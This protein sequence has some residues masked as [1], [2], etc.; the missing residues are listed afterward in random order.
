MIRRLLLVGLLAGALA[1]C[2][3]SAPVRAGR[4]SPAP[5]PAPTTVNCHWS[6]LDLD[7]VQ[8][9]HLVDAG[10]PPLDVPRNRTA[11]M[12]IDTDLGV[13]EIDMDARRTP[14]AVAS[15]AHLAGRGFFDGTA[16]HRLTR[17]GLSVLQCGDPSGNGTGGPTY[18]YAEED[19]AS[20]YPGGSPP[21]SP[22]GPPSVPTLFCVPDDSANA[23]NDVVCGPG[24]RLSPAP[25]EPREDTTVI[26]R[27][28]TVGV[29]RTSEPGTSGSQFFVSYADNRLDADY[30]PLGTV[31]RGLDVIDTVARGGLT[32]SSSDSP[33]EGTPNT[34]LVLRRVTVVYR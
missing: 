5:T 2:D 10:Y 11:V 29:A 8:R 14:C 4:L 23:Q 32:P 19:T 12:T 22:T 18:R 20:L 15:F 25:H 34:R 1:A 27:R 30:T 7:T 6:L 16:C 24:Q 26:Y 3:A 28:G 31:T 13:I 9:Y 33:D 17:G 21:P